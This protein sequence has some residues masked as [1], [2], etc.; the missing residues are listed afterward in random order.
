M[1]EKQRQVFDRKQL[2]LRLSPE[3]GPCHHP[4]LK[5]M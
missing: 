5:S 2:S 3:Q 1:E 4:F